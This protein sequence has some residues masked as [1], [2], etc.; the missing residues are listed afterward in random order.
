MSPLVCQITIVYHWR[1]QRSSIK[2]VLLYDLLL[3]VYSQTHTKITFKSLIKFADKVEKGCVHRPLCWPNGHQCK[4]LEGW[5][6][7]KQHLLIPVSPT[8]S[9]DYPLSSLRY[10]NVH[11]SAWCRLMFLL[12]E[13]F[14]EIDEA[15]G[16]GSIDTFTLCGLQH[17]I[18]F[19]PRTL[20]RRQTA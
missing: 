5:T 16:G 12:T 4:R 17:F 11:Q 10:I 8:C 15:L 1:V 2:S 19:E 9:Q 7:I 18:W 3:K 6:V 13:R 14:G 20:N